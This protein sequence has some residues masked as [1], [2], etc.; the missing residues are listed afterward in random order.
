MGFRRSEESLIGAGTGM[1]AAGSTQGEGIGF[2]GSAA[3]SPIESRGH[4]R[5][6]ESVSLRCPRPAA[7]AGGGGSLAGDPWRGRDDSPGLRPQSQ[8]QPP[9]SRR[10]A[11]HEDGHSRTDRINAPS[12]PRQAAE[13]RTHRVGSQPLSEKIILFEDAGPAWRGSRPRAD[14]HQAVRLNQ[15]VLYPLPHSGEGAGTPADAGRRRP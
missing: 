10:A 8:P 12:P 15:S 9:C 11:R 6:E 2:R 7:V 14:G 4:G 1:S 3:L 5:H 13:P